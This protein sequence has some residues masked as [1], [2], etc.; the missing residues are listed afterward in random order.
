MVELQSSGVHDIESHQRSQDVRCKEILSKWNEIETMLGDHAGW[1]R[2]VLTYNT[3]VTDKR[4][5]VK[6]GEQEKIPDYFGSLET[7]SWRYQ[8]STQLRAEWYAVVEYVIDILSKQ[9]TEIALADSDKSV[10]TESKEQSINVVAALDHMISAESQKLSTAVTDYVK[11]VNDKTGANIDAKDVLMA[12][13]GAAAIVLARNVLGKEFAQAATTQENGSGVTKGLAVEGGL[14]EVILRNPATNEPYSD[15]EIYAQWKEFIESGAEC[16]SL[17]AMSKTGLRYDQQ[18]GVIER[19]LNFV[20]DYSKEHEKQIVV[21]IDAVQLGGRDDFSQITR[22]L[23]DSRVHAVAHSGS[24]APGGAPHAGFLLL[25]TKGKEKAAKGIQPADVN[26][27]INDLEVSYAP[28]L[29]QIQDA[30]DIQQLNLMSVMRGT[31]NARAVMDLIELPEDRQLY[32]ETGREMSIVI[33]TFFEMLGYKLLFTDD[34]QCSIVAFEPPEVFSPSVVQQVLLPA[35]S[36]LGI[37]LGGYLQEPQAGT[38]I[39]RASV[40]AQWL[41]DGY[42]AADLFASFF[43]ELSFEEVKDWYQVYSQAHKSR[44][45]NLLSDLA[46][47]CMKRDADN[48]QI[49][50]NVGLLA[51][52]AEAMVGTLDKAKQKE[53]ELPFTTGASFPYMYGE[54]LL[55]IDMSVFVGNTNSTPDSFSNKK[56]VTDTDNDQAKEWVMVVTL[57]DDR[58]LRISSWGDNKVKILEK[59]ENKEDLLSRLYF[60]FRDRFSQISSQDIFD[61]VYRSDVKRAAREAVDSVLRE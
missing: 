43:G 12:G 60:A 3:P 38:P 24:K 32:G 15:D 39:L 18:N 13:S 6:R 46:N 42:T 40:N 2:H 5:R 14:F 52:A 36:T 29:E 57:P 10:V 51:N 49:F 16:L 55:Q 45:K 27:W 22:W 34:A 21:I 8:L 7:S 1:V 59:P 11:T 19:V 17:T 25:S 56:I 9:H 31:D 33:Q 48:K 47:G 37:E 41:R 53:R 35:L 26:Q 28:I 23:H 58:V 20:Q 4:L 50:K 30:L 61:S 54:T 44:R